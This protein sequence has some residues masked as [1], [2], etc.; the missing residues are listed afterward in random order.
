MYLFKFEVVTNEA[1]FHE[2]IQHDNVMAAWEVIG[3]KYPV[4]EITLKLF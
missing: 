1:K 3:E 2:Y 4:S